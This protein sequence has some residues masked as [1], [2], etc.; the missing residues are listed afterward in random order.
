MDTGGIDSLVWRHHAWRNHLQSVLL[1]AVLAGFLGLLGWLLWGGL[2]IPV[3]L[4]VGVS[5]VLLNPGLSP[6]WVMRLYGASPIPP[7][8]APA[9]WHTLAELTVRAGLPVQPLLYYV[10]S[11]MLNAFAVGGR[12]AAAIAVTDGLLRQLSLREL[13]GILAHEISHVRNN[14]LRVMGLADMFSRL[15][16]MLSL[17]GQLLVLIN[18]PLVLFGQAAINWSA[19]L[20]LVFAPTFS[21]L[22][23]LALSRTREYDADLNAARLTRDP[24]GLATAL[25]RIEQLQGDWLERTMLPGRHS[26]DPSL[27]RSHPDTSER[28]A[29]LL[30]LRP[31]LADGMPRRHDQTFDA[32][33]VFGAPVERP[34]RRHVSGLWH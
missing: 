2:G 28:I 24:D 8:Q 5:G 19:I 10:P 26:P 7:D 22:A 33:P 3:L 25:A 31:E 14:D 4:A 11:R 12:D 13:A 18:L 1:L 20:L 23:Q 27:L 9:L 29:R 15:T 32:R 34:P 21:A 17:I 30:A 6:R 16:R